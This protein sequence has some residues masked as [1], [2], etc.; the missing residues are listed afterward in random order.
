MRNKFLYLILFFSF[1]LIHSSNAQWYIMSTKEDSLVQ[2]GIDNI[3]NMNFGAAEKIYNLVQ[4][5]YPNNLAGYFLQATSD[6]WKVLLNSSTKEYDKAF[7]NSINKVITKSQQT[8]D[9]AKFDV[10]AIFFKAAGIGYRA[11]FY[12]VR[13]QWV[14]AA[15]DGHQAYQMLVEGLKIAPGNRDMLF[16]IGYYNY[17]S[18]VFPQQYPLLKPL[19]SFIPAGDKN[20]GIKQ[21]KASSESAKYADIEASIVLMQIYYQFEKDYSKAMEIARKLNNKYPSNPYFYKYIGRLSY[22]LGDFA[23]AS[24]IWYNILLK[25]GKKTFGYDDALAREAMYYYGDI[26]MSN[27][28]YSRALKYLTASARMSKKVDKET[29]G[30]I[31]MSNLKL[32]MIYDIQGNRAKA[33]EYY[34]TVLNS[35]DYSGSKNKA[36]DYLKAPFRR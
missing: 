31:T 1:C 26:L 34:K 35:A 12:T 9:T 20:L 22:T 32:G 6:W 13:E 8:L 30:F 36:R 33:M 24:K 16:G 23:E 17:F 7:L 10:V 27:G 4:K 21:I 14:S 29:S 3:Y 25:G 11:R 28:E 19:I 5:Q 18:Q 15:M 2:L